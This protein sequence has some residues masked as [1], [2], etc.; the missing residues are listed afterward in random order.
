MRY[1]FATTTVTFLVATASAH[2]QECDRVG[3]ETCMNGAIHQCM[4]AGDVE[5]CVNLGDDV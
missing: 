2:A 3:A 5:L 1:R 4:Q